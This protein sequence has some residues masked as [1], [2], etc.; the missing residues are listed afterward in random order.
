MGCWPGSGRLGRRSGP[1][2][3]PCLGSIQPARPLMP[4]SRRSPDRWLKSTPPNT[5]SIKGRCNPGNPRTPQIFP[6]PAQ[7]Q[8]STGGGG[9]LLPRGRRPRAAAVSGA[10][11][12]KPRQPPFISFLCPPASPSNPPQL[13]PSRERTV[14]WRVAALLPALSPARA[15]TPWVSARPSSGPVVAPKSMSRT[16]SRRRAPTHQVPHGGGYNP[17]MG[18]SPA[19]R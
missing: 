8:H 1:A 17:H 9:L 3:H 19:A 12:P 6:P 10:A 2:P 16:P 4:R 15:S 11:R 14:A 5:C 18:G 13:I 7:R